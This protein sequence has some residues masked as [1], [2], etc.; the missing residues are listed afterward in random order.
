LQ[1]EVE[2]MRKEVVEK[3]REVKALRDN[4][5]EIGRR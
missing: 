1:A 2:G 5:L 4:I 3:V